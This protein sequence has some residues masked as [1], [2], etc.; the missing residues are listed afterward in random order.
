MKNSII[1]NKWSDEYREQQEKLRGNWPDF[2]PDKLFEH[3]GEIYY[4]P[5]IQPVICQNCGV[6]KKVWGNLW[7]PRARQDSRNSNWVWG[8]LWSFCPDCHYVT[9][10]A[11]NSRT[12]NWR[13]SK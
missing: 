5:Y 6:L 9:N 1:L 2:L 7:V 4:E 13:G 8:N 12:S 3:F 10:L 11:V